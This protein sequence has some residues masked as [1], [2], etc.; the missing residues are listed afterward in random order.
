MVNT[1]NG[2]A[3]A[4]AAQQNGAPPSPLTLVQA[5]IS[6]LD[7]RDRQTEL[8]YQLVQNSTCG[9]NGVRNAQ[10]QAL[11]TYGKFLAT[12]P[13]TFAEAGESLEVDHWLCTMESKFRLLH[14]TEYQKT[15]FTT[16]QLLENVGTWWANY[17]AI[18][19]ENYQ[20]MWAKFRDAFH[21]HHIST[22]I[23]KRKHQEFMDLKQG[24]R[25]VHD[26]SKLSNHLVQ[27]APE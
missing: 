5:I 21:A 23:M 20:V 10:G 17:T 4:E 26:Y 12:H 9:G 22:I 13:P 19:P 11:T 25:F 2:R 16:Q 18:R 14:C 24:G 1:R 8:L 3:E 7:S 15:L 6:I 27:Y